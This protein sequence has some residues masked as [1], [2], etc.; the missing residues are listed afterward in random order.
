M[1]CQALPPPGSGGATEVIQ[2][3]L[4][5]AV[6][7]ASPPKDR[8]CWGRNQELAKCRDGVGNAA[9]YRARAEAS[10]GECR[11]FAIPMIWPGGHKKVCLFNKNVRKEKKER[12]KRTNPRSQTAQA[13]TPWLVPGFPVLEERPGLSRVQVVPG[14]LAGGRTPLQPLCGGCCRSPS[15]RSLPLGSCQARFQGQ[16]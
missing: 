4:E 11:A 3:S 7:P 10:Q 9:E 13:A 8:L 16:N 5:A 1:K 14:S 2:P 15:P 12:K 6:L